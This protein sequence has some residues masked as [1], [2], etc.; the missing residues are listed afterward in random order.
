MAPSPSRRAALT[1]GFVGFRFLA[2]CY[3]KLSETAF[4]GS[5]LDAGARLMAATRHFR[6]SCTNWRPSAVM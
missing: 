5:Y 4:A 2:V 1:E 6:N 3:T